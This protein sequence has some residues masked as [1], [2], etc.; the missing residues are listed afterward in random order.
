MSR[1][2]PSI[3]LAGLFMLAVWP[4]G[5]QAQDETWPYQNLEQTNWLDQLQPQEGA[6]NWRVSLGGGALYGPAY[7]GSDKYVVTPLP[8]ISVDYKDGLFFA[9]FWDGIGSYPLQG[10]NYKLG[11]SIGLAL[12]RQEDDDK[13]NL[14]GMGDIDLGVTANLMGEYSFGPIQLSGKIS[15]GNKDYGTTAKMELGTMFFATE[16]LTLMASAGATWADEDHMKSY[17]GVS[18]AQSARSGY[19]R[20][21][22][23][24]GMKSI[25]FTAGAFYS[26]TEHVDVKLMFMGDQLLG[27]AADSPI[28]KNDFN[29]SV[30][31]T[32]SYTFDF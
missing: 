4:A 15:K 18:A 20:Y 22:I 23:E 9:N 3:V 13:K 8:D 31:L 19:R 28:T 26:I 17:F 29:P 25:N 12:G 24:S 21:D 10:E 5:A 16:K 14:R 30:F 27:D 2:L 1:N 32:T 7:E 6:K 11:G